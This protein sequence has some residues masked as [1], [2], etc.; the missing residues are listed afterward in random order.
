MHIG[1]KHP[2]HADVYQLGRLPGGAGWGRLEV[3]AAR[4]EAHPEKA[5]LRVGAL[6]PWGQWVGGGGPGSP[7]STLQLW[8]ATA[9][10]LRQF[11]NKQKVTLT[12]SQTEVSLEVCFSTRHVTGKHS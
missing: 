8:K 2:N 10:F 12:P 4:G 9:R 6:G 11:E 3:R 7:L 5:G 1:G